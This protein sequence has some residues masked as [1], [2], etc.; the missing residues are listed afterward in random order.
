[1]EDGTL[2]VINKAKDAFEL[3]LKLAFLSSHKEKKAIAYKIEDN[4]LF[5]YDYMAEKNDN[6]VKLAYPHTLDDAINF[7]WGWYNNN[8][9]KYAQPDTDGSVVKGFRIT[10][11]NTGWQNKDYNTFVCVVPVWL[12]YGK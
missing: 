12:I 1:M 10:T 4:S 11:E 3:A 7:C 2:N 5:L 6:H 8:E 9:P